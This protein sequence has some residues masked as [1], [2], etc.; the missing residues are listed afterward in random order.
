[1]TSA[2]ALPE[3]SRQEVRR[4]VLVSRIAGVLIAV[5]LA[6]GSFYIHRRDLGSIGSISQLVT[7]VLGLG[8]FVSI[9]TLARVGHA[10]ALERSLSEV[11]QLSDQLRDLAERDS[12]T[13]L[14]NL[15]AFHELLESRI[16]DAMTSGGN[17]SLI[18]ADLDN[19]KLLNDAYGHQFGDTV[20][21][22]AGRVFA[23]AGGCDTC[24]ARL[25]GD[26]FAL[27]VPNG[28]RDAA[29]KVARHIESELSTVKFEHNQPA[30]L[31]SFGVGTY[32]TDG[33]TAQAL[34]AAAD[35]RMYGEKHR[36]KAESLTT[37]AGASRKLLVRTGRAMRPDQTTTQILEE[38]ANAAREEF[39]LS[40]CVISVQAHDH[41]PMLT[42]VASDVPGLELACSAASAG[43]TLGGP[44]LAGLLPPEAWLVE[45]P[46]PDEFGDGGT[47]LLAGLPMTSFRPDAPVVVALADL[48]QAVV[49]NGRAH[50]DAVRAGRERDI[51]IDLARALAVGGT[52]RERLTQVSRMIA[53]FIGVPTVSIEGL[54]SSADARASYNIAWG[55]PDEMLRQWG[56]AR[57]TSQGREFI[58][59]LA[60]AAPCILFDPG[61]D[62]SIPERERR[63]L[64]PAAAIAISPIRFDG[65][66]LGLLAAISRS[67]DYFTEDLVAVLMTIADHLAPAINVALLRDE[68]EAS[69]VQLEQASRESLARLAD[70]AEARDPHTGG[71]LRR[72]RHYSVALAGEMGL[73]EMEAEAIGAASA[74]HDLGKLSLP[75]EV[76]MRTGK[77]TDDDWER[78]RAHPVQGERLIG[79]SPMFEIERAVA[80]WHHERWDGTGYPDGMRGEQ[81]PLCA[82]IVA[83]ADAFDA[84]TTERPYK[85]AWPLAEA[86]GE[87]QRQKGRLFCPSVV[88]ALEALWG[89]GALARA[90]A[91]ADRDEHPDHDQVSK[92]A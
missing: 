58:Q 75:D 54:G 44:M 51:H 69:Y 34:F 28:G 39:S 11:R 27:L 12:L 33:E 84:L 46:I 32:P 64:A 24:A 30:M 20:L 43:G 21:R 88:Q 89:S 41:H 36:R 70:A 79:D 67:A 15:R 42:I 18:V 65:E 76:L 19:F 85:A 13:G 29:V 52:L 78:M 17:V 59:R 74:I 4:I 82:R 14:Y 90:F 63:M 71:H 22:E 31:G 81:I 49:A 80:R 77:L 10:R 48:M 57:N 83:V 73:S 61:Q 60:A 91:E 9:S 47:L 25:G 45:T 50:V 40:A 55:V 2:A 5:A 23:E 1:V 53:E 26:E 37:L 66:V 38:I 87:V 16:A 7:V 3:E 35:G 62:E 56:V 8:S 68:L 6:I 72:I 86:V 92:A